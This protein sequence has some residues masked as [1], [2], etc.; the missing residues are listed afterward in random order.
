MPGAIQRGPCT[1][2]SVEP[3][4]SPSLSGRGVSES[5]AATSFESLPHSCLSTSWSSLG[6]SSRS[7]WRS[8]LTRD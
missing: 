4:E 5:R 6:S 2:G 3:A 1:S 8:R 7:A